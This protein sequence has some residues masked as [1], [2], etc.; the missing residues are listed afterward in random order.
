MTACVTPRRA[1]TAPLRIAVFRFALRRG[2]TR[3]LLRYRK[4]AAL[5][6]V[7]SLALWAF[8]LYA[9]WGKPL[10]FVA[11]FLLPFA[12]I[13]AGGVLGV[14]LSVVTSEAWYYS[15]APG[16]QSMVMLWPRWPVLLPDRR[17]AGNWVAEPRGEGVG[18]P[19]LEAVLRNVD[20]RGIWIYGTAA[21]DEL[22]DFYVS[23][24]C[25]RRND[26]RGLVRRPQA[27]IGA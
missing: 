27:P 21:D 9:Y 26:R 15:P 12:I 20:Q 7:L 3:Q 17:F 4:A 23:R 1:N 10:A 19:L 2:F 13:G 5:Y 16:K 14:F 25:E 22:L 24:G 18:G 11:C 6:A 8:A